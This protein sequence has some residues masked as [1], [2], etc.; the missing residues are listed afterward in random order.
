VRRQGRYGSGGAGVTSGGAGVTSGGAGVTSGGAGVTSGGAGVTSGGV[1][2]GSAVGV[3][4]GVASGGVGSAVGVGVGSAVATGAGAGVGRGGWNGVGHGTQPCGGDAIGVPAGPGVGVEADGGAAEGDPPARGAGVTATHEPPGP[5]LGGLGAI[6]GGSVPGD[7]AV[8]RPGACT[9]NW[10]SARDGGAERRASAS[11]AGSFG[12]APETTTAS[13]ARTTNADDAMTP[14]PRA[15]RRRPILPLTR[16]V[17]V[18]GPTGSPACAAPDVRV[19]PS[20]DQASDWRVLGTARTTGCPSTSGPAL[21][22]PFLP[23][24]ARPGS[25]ELRTGRW[26]DRSASRK[27]LQRRHASSTRFQQSEQLATPHREQVWNEMPADTTESPSRPQR[28]QN[29]APIS[30]LH[31][32]FAQPTGGCATC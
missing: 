13:V 29:W 19:A 2:V 27:G 14:A 31:P 25:R 12:D 28:S 15:P 32:T 3:G 20:D 24:S 21:T 10:P 8:V 1:G 9:V 6:A 30:T 26:L 23:R 18:T 7:G 11:G 16:A 17:S 5:D 4:V 22:R